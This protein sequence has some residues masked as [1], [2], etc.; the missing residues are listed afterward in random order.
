VAILGLFGLTGMTRGGPP[1]VVDDPGT[2]EQGKGT[3]LLR[4]ELVR[5]RSQNTHALPA[6]TLTLGLPAKLELALDAAYLRSGADGTPEEG[7]RDPTIGIKWRFMDQDGAV[8]AVAVAYTLSI[9]AGRHGLSADT[10]IHAP[11][12][13]LG[14]QFDQRWHLFGAIGAVVPESGLQR[15]QFFAGVGVGYQATESWLIG[16]DLSGITRAG[17]DQRSDLSVGLAAQ[18]DL[19][20]SWTLMGRV[21]RS[22][23]GSQDIVVFIGIQ[24]NF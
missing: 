21:G 1:F 5:E 12:L 11:S 18:V 3:L 16:V 2:V 8:P 17:A 19:S 4:Y 7:I 20:D 9:P 13:T 24:L 14:W 15:D 6:V 10:T 22:V 23:S